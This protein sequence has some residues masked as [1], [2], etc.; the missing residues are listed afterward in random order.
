MMLS[1]RQILDAT[2]G[3]IITDDSAGPRTAAQFSQDICFSGLS[4]DS[5][6]ISQG[7]LFLALKGDRFDG[8]DFVRDAL[9]TGAGAIVN[10][11]RTVRHTA[12][13]CTI[14]VDDTL[15][16]LHAIARHI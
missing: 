1:A 2:G 12:G 14:L 10:R 7:E 16:A 11:G 4:I 8:H 3:A 9:K 13:K 15:F 6:T 5:R